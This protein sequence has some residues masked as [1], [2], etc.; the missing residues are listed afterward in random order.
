MGLADILA[1]GRQQQA[2]MIDSQRAQGQSQQAAQYEQVRPQ[3][4]AMAKNGFAGMDRRQ[5]IN[6]MEQNRSTLS[7]APPDVRNAIMAAYEKAIGIR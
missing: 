2:Q 4:E 3:L 5:A 6:W 7:L 1:A